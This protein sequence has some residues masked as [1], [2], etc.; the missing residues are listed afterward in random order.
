MRQK[1][2]IRD[3]LLSFVI[4]ESDFLK[5]PGL[6]LGLYSAIIKPVFPGLIS[7]LDQFGVVQ[8]Q[9]GLTVKILTGSL[10]LLVKLLLTLSF[11]FVK[12]SFELL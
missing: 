9:E 7:S 11:K 12:F 4:T 6:P 2:K 5:T 3:L 10:L 8:P 1:V